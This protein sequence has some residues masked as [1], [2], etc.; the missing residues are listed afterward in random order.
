MWLASPKQK[1]TD[2]D[3]DW[4]RPEPIPTEVFLEVTGKLIGQ[5]ADR[6]GSLGRGE[7]ETD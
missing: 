6:L 7:D 1:Y 5:G 3:I 4:K 2:G